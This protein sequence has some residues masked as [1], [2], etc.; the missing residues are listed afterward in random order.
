MPHQPLYDATAH[1]EEQQEAESQRPYDAVGDNLDRIDAVEEGEVERERPPESVR[2][3]AEEQSF[4]EFGSGR[5]AQETVQ[6]SLPR[7]SDVRSASP[8]SRTLATC[9]R[10][11]RS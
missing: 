11:R 6:V 2:R 5:G 4:R 3:K 10:T 7:I 8:D 9:S 1:D